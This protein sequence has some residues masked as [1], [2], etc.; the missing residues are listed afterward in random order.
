[1]RCAPLLASQTRVFLEAST[2]SGMHSRWYASG[3]RAQ[4][5]SAPLPGAPSS[6]SHRLQVWDGL[7]AAGPVFGVQAARLHGAEEWPL[8]SQWAK[9]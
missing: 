7:Q 5:I 3:Q 1:M 2:A 4:G 8:T 6:C 9:L